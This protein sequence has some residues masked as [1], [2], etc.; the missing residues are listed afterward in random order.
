M[1]PI[2]ADDFLF[3]SKELDSINRDFTMDSLDQWETVS[4]LTEAARDLISQI[5]EGALSHIFVLSSEHQEY[6]E[7]D[8]EGLASVPE[9]SLFIGCLSMQEEPLLLKDVFENNQLEDPLLQSLFY[10]SYG[11]R[12]IL[13]VKHRFRLLAFILISPGRKQKKDLN[14]D[15]L[16]LIDQFLQRLKINLYAAYVAD[17]RQRNLL[18]LAEFPRALQRYNSMQD[19]LGGILKEISGKVPFDRGIFYIYDDYHKLLVPK[20]WEGFEERP[21]SIP[22]SL[23]VSGYSFHSRRAVAVQNRKTHG[24]FASRKG[25]DFIQGSF[26]CAP[27][28]TDKRQFGVLTLCRST[29]RTHHPFGTEQRYMMEIIAS[30]TAAELDSR[31]I[32]DEL[33]N[34]YFSTI[35]SLNR[36]LEARDIYTLGHSERVMDYSIGICQE[37]GLSESSIRTI[38]YAAILHDIGKVGIRDSIISKCDKLSEDEYKAIKEHTEIGY[39]IL[40]SHGQ[41]GE[42]RQLIRYHHERMDGNGYYGKKLGDYPWEVMIISLADIY[43]A[44]TSKR[45]YRE[46]F[47]PNE[48]MIAIEQLVDVHFDMPIYQAFHR[49]L[50]KKKL[51]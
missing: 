28:Y 39:E 43:D 20:S 48:A 24:S 36:A 30:F 25:E 37:L 8:R 49:F 31:L 32:Y 6:R 19:I 38:R 21:P 17:N 11:A 51:I 47:A 50:E 4:G 7:M 12:W 2:K 5:I 34:S 46:P 22:S 14:A 3:S 35:S 9:D 33:E 27:V 42:I 1:Q 18:S 26:V 10:D 15:D 16:N 29:Q 23:G 40:D 41:W 44:L 13:P 45:P